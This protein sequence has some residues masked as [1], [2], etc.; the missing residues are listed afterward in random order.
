MA[1]WD[2]ITSMGNVEDR[3]GMTP[4]VAFAGAGGLITLL[5]TVGLNYL[6]LNV[7]PATVQEVVNSVSAIQ[8]ST[9]SQQEQ[10]P[11]FRGADSYEVFTQRVLGS[12]NDVWK[13]VFAENNLTYEEPRLV[14]YRQATQSACGVAASQVGPHYCPEDSTI[15]LDETFF[16]ELQRRFGSNTGDVAQA[17]VIAHEVGHNVQNQLGLFGQS[18]MQTQDGMI[19]AELQADCYAGVWAYAINKNGVFESGEIN[20][21]LEAA[22]AVGDDHIQKTQTGTVNPETWTHGSS[23]Q[24]AR[25]F[26]KGYTTGKPG[27]C[28][29][30]Q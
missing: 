27:Q 7:S 30:L 11:E 8:N 26:E 12:S 4:T 19:E 14:L 29:N 10:P 24:R 13:R 3:R 5:L 28:V 9:V 2:R 6:G 15:Y 1:N 17:Y 23:E 18:S 25:A 20:Q 16:D 22:A 21:A